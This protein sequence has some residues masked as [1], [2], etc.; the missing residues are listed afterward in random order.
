MVEYIHQQK[1]PNYPNG[2]ILRPSMNEKGYLQIN[3]QSTIRKK[4]CWK[5]HRLVMIYFKFIKGCQLLEV[6]HLNGI[7]TDNRIWNLEWVTTGTNVNRCFIKGQD[8]YYCDYIKMQLSNI[9]QRNLYY[10]A[11]NNEDPI[12]LANEYDVPLDYVNNLIKGAIPPKPYFEYNY[13]PY[14]L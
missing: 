9:D 3:L 6:D 1:S 10:R 11:L 4:T 12:R 7:K 2:G 5:I 8:Q 13:A 14:N